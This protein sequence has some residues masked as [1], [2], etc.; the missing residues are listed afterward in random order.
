MHMRVE[1][2]DN[3]KRSLQL[4]F[5]RRTTK[6]LSRIF[7]KSLV[8][9]AIRS[10]INNVF[11]FVSS[12]TIDFLRWSRDRDKC[13]LCLIRILIGTVFKSFGSSWKKKL[14]EKKVP[15]DLTSLS[16]P[17]GL[18]WISSAFK[19]TDTSHC[20]VVHGTQGSELHLF[21]LFV[22]LFLYTATRRHT[23]VHTH[24]HRHK[25]TRT[26]AHEC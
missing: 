3:E 4:F 18:R 6:D 7:N 25:H 24:G 2:K 9:F 16:L 11:F 17:N 12:R 8:I 15:F 14:E 26:H 13:A 21:S 19:T 22:F 5:V 20:R 23:H 1:K 10:V